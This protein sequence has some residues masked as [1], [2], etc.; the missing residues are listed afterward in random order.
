MKINTP[1]L[2]LRDL[3]PSDATS[4]HGHVNNL[5][6][7]KHLL[8][9]EYPAEIKNTRGFIR[10]SMK[11]AKQKPRTTYNLTIVLKSEKEP[12]GMIGLADINHFQGSGMIG[13]WLSE[14]HWRNGYMSEAL[15]AMIGFAFTKLKL[16]RLD[17]GAFAENKASNALIKKMGFTYE[18]TTR[19]RLRSKA[20]GKYHDEHIYGLLKNEWK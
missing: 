9:V 8:A 10:K 3:Q 2:I 19:Q 16:H 11:D 13:Y 1:R 6:V 18:G 4:I 5:N 20:T 15:R 14:K 7:T 17:V 12:I